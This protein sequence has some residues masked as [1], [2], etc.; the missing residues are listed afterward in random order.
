MAKNDLKMTKKYLK[1]SK[2][3]QNKIKIR[4]D[5]VYV[6]WDRSFRLLSD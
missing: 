2:K 4:L 5:V 6:E 3:V 1:M